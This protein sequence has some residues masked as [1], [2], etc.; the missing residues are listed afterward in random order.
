M[1]KKNLIDY[2][3]LKYRKEFSR[4]SHKI[5]ASVGPSRETLSRGLVFVL[6]ASTPE[7]KKIIGY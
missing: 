7:E 4:A 2:V 1:P 3:T 5:L 6:L